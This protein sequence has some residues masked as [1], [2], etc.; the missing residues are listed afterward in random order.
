M[1]TKGVIFDEEILDELREI[2]EKKGRSLK[3]TMNMY[4]SAFAEDN[5]TY[6]K[7][8]ADDYSDLL[9]LE[10]ILEDEETM[11]DINRESEQTGESPVSIAQR[12]VDFMN[13]LLVHADPEMR[14]LRQQASLYSV[15]NQYKEF[16]NEKQEKY[17]KAV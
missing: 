9:R 6:Q 7:H 15:K 16:A 14:E 2:S 3:D 4:A 17:K 12:L 11:A 13:D 8:F 10:D 5:L 1:D